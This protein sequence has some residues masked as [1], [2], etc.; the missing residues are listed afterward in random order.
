MKIFKKVLYV[1]VL[2]WPLASS[3][4]AYDIKGNSGYQDFQNWKV[5]YSQEGAC[6][7]AFPRNPDHMQQDMKMRGTEGKLRYD[8]YVADHQKKKYL[9]SS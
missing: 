5:V 1:T 7:A 2:A 3:L 9:W 8:V 6:K 4:S